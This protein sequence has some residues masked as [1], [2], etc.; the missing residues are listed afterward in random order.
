MLSGS[1]ENAISSNHKKG[2]RTVKSHKGAIRIGTCS[3][4]IRSSSPTNTAAAY[5]P[6][7]WIIVDM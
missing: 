6:F 5:L 1:L 2:N 7:Y 3:V 4:M